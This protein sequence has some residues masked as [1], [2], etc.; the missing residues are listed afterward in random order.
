MALKV[1][2]GSAWVVV[3][4]HV[5]VDTYHDPYTDLYG[6]ITPN[7]KRYTAGVYTDTYTD[8]YGYVDV[9]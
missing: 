5:Y 3:T 7:T 2:N 9:D 6:W 1:W 8:N 4:M